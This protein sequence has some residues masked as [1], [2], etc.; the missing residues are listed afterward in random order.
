MNRRS[1]RGQEAA[2]RHIREAEDFSR[3]LGGTDKDVKEYFFALSPS[4]IDAVLSVYGQ[5]YGSQK[6][7]YARET[8]GSWKT[9]KRRMS[10]LVAKRLFN[11]LP[12][13]M[14]LD[15]KYELAEN[16]WRHFGPS[17]R[18]SFMVGTSADIKEI[19]RVLTQKLD[20]AVSTYELPENILKRFDWLSAGDVRLKEKLLNHFRQ[21]EKKLCVDRVKAEMPLLQRQMAQH[22]DVTA[23]A[24]SVIQIDKHEISI[25]VDK[26]LE[27]E[28]CEGSPTVHTSDKTFGFNWIWWLVGAG[29]LFALFSG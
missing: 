22:S 9:G 21:E 13:R 4:E 6:E 15:K 29:I 26:K 2:R 25:W 17:S 12:P 8:Y 16:I 23:L 5:Q 3:E 28:I 20:D 18:T 27:D 7:S 10:G 14:P 1:S 19:S 11:L 24:K